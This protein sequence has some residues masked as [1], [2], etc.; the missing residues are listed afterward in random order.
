[1]NKKSFCAYILLVLFLL[2]TSCKS[3]P[4]SDTKTEAASS[5]VVSENNTA[6]S[7]TTTAPVTPS[8]PTTPSVPET[9]AI[10]EISSVPVTPTIPETP[11]VPANSTTPSVPEI[12]VVPS[13]SV[14][15]EMLTD[16]MARA[17]AAR[18]RAV[19]FESPAYFPSEWDAAD[20]LYT[21]AANMQKATQNDVQQAASMYDTSA[22]AY[23]EIFR[24]TIPLYAQAREDEIMEAREK[25]INTGFRNY[26]PEYVQDADDKAL[27]AYKQFEAE[28]YYNARDTATAALKEY[29][30]L[31]TGAKIL[32]VRR[33]IIERDFV[34]YDAY[35]F[36]KADEAALAVNDE[37]KAGNKNTAMA[38]AE[39]VLRRYNNILANGWKAYVWE[40]RAAAVSEKEKALN[41]KANIASR[42]LFREADGIFNNAER[43]FASQDYQN[44]AV[45]YT[46]S[47]ER[48]SLSRLDTEEKRRKALEIIKMAE[49]KIDESNETAIDAER[50]IEGAAK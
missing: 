22:D 39:G 6:N 48:F 5:G 49:E 42:D 8:V 47:V 1:M 41:E 40:K 25:L 12:P 50:T 38:N 4:S 29:E 13:V 10:P 2:I 18:E 19:D 24:K 21:V 11:S 44:A 34:K 28:D 14:S 43:S 33:E 20:S 15:T 16:Q 9:P 32:M 45:S 3:N 35:N 31:Y 23:D 26:F 30:D 17:D 7:T 27:L 46:D 37:Y 36:E